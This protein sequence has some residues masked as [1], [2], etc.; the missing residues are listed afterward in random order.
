MVGVNAATRQPR[1]A[2]ARA[3]F[4][5]V[6][7]YFGDR[8]GKY[9]DGNQ[10][11]VRGA[12]TVAAFDTPVS[13]NLIGDDFNRADLC[14]LGHVH[15][16]HMAGLH[17]LRGKPVHV[18]EADLP[19][20]RSWDALADV[21]GYHGAERE[22]ARRRFEEEFHYVPTPDAIPYADGAVWDLGGGVRVR[23][24]HLPG[25]T[26]GHCAL[27]VEPAGVA[28]IGDIDLSSFGPYYGDTNSSL[29]DFRESL[30]KVAE[31]PASVWITFH[32]KGVYTDRATFEADLAAY[33]GRLAERERKLLAMLA[34]GPQTVAQLAQRRLLYPPHVT[35]SWV[36]DVEA[37]SIAMHLDELLAGGRVVADEGGRYRLP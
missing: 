30:A 16:D 12:D 19:A 15:E 24:I 32:H 13:A 27:L 35:E 34:D 6:T 8:N 20:A 3:D 26:P 25:H 18:H 10:V 37:R 14:I 28:F 22:E 36:N 4:G 29:R 7:V 33:A 5:P 31:I 9:P 11:I 17:L 1:P 2:L 23:A 21:F